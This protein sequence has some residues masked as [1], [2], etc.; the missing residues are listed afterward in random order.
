[1]ETYSKVCEF[2]RSNW[3]YPGHLNG[4]QQ[5]LNLLPVYAH[6]PKTVQLDWINDCKWLKWQVKRWY[7]SKRQE[8]FFL[9]VNSHV[10]LL[11]QV[12]SCGNDR[13]QTVAAL[14]SHLPAAERGRAPQADPGHSHLFCRAAVCQAVQEAGAR[15]EAP[16]PGRWSP[17][18][19]GGCEREEK[20]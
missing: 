19:V 6:Q 9:K 1:M 12:E 2:M 11:H 16:H 13:Y 18:S 7:V 8:S 17:K 4:W 14:Q 5:K 10:K 3:G 20:T 15:R